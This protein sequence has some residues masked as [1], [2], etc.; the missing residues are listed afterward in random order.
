MPDSEY[1]IDPEH[2]VIAKI[3]FEAY[4]EAVGGKTYDE[5][6]IPSWENLSGDGD[7]TRYAWMVATDRAIEAYLRREAWMP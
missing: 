3:A 7:R 1:K 5:K 4:C 2:L 6:E